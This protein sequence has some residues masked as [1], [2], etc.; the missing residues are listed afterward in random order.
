M[1]ETTRAPIHPRLVLLVAAVLPGVGQV[2]NR[3]PVRGLIFVFFM[4]LLGTFTAVTADPGVSVLGRYAGG[5]FV[6][7]LALIDAYK[8]AR[9]R[10]EVWRHRA[11]RG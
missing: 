3:Q 11:A 4:L 10:F 8:V 7:A 9:V 6:Y 2:V 5:I 1:S